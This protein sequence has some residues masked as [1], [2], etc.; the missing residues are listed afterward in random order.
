MF[1]I[2]IAKDGRPVSGSVVERKKKPSGGRWVAIDTAIPN[3]CDVIELTTH[4]ASV[5]KPTGNT[6]SLD[7]DALFGVSGNHTYTLSGISDPDGAL[8]NA[9]VLPGN[10]LDIETGVVGIAYVTLIVNK[11]SAQE[12]VVIK[13]TVE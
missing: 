10:Y 12:A 1:F 6:S 9:T 8:V 11:N 4:L 3:C 13:L 7:L 5:S 2:R